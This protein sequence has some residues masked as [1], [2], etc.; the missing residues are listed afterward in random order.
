MS[1]QKTDNT[2]TAAGGADPIAVKNPLMEMV[3]V[4]A[5]MVVTMTSYT[6]MQFI[7]GMMVSRIG[8]DEVYV[9]AQGNGG[10]FVWLC[11]SFMLG[12]ATV[13][14]TYV[15]QHLGAGRPERGAAYAWNG[16]WLSLLGAIMMLPLIFALPWVFSRMNHGDQLHQL[17]T[18][19]A[20]I[21]LGGAFLTMG[22]RSIAHYFYG[23]H[24]PMVVMVS[25][26]LANIVNIGANALLIFG[27]AGPPESM[28]L[29]GPIGQLAAALNLPAMGVSGAAWGT[30][31]GT[32]VEFAIPMLVFVGPAMHRK[33]ATRTVWRPSIT[34]IKDIMRIGWPGGLMFFN[35]MVCWGYL[36]AFLLGAA[37]EAAGQ[38][39]E[40]HNTAG[41][42][43]LR[44]M[45]VSFM[46]A[47]G[48][49]IAVTAIVGRC[50]GMGRPDLAAKRAW[51][52]LK[53]TVVYMG[54]CGLA[55]IIFREQLIGVFIPADMPAAKVD[56]LVR[57]GAT[58]MIAAAVFQLFDAV[59]IITSGA[60]RGAGDT[61]WPGV[62]TVIASWT[63]IVGGG[64]LLIWLAPGLGSLGPW[65][66]ASAY[67]IV[68]GVAMMARF[69]GG[70]WRT[71]D[72][73][74][75]RD[76]EGI[77]DGTISLPG[78]PLTVPADAV[79][80]TTPGSL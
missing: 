14:N 5:P 17:E 22:A 9:S 50:M 24:R 69:I 46:P 58:V 1:S 70:R 32:C 18:Q 52:G 2:K 64:H 15:A 68:L 11:M 3:Q 77:G 26:L 61:V 72:L 59:A 19:Y 42:I 29:A 13:V 51:L 49:G 4:A 38:D 40:V 74:K 41:W 34:H 56:E 20:Q 30:V 57:V 36:M 37:G 43:A 65:I 12:L 23:M 76:E 79:A 25:V 48:L 10:M 27:A 28:P 53:V 8:P 6:V 39:A 63:C 67:I 73:L 7:D 71:I 44:Y 66:G 31:I 62:V 75:H 78:E 54:L 35:E 21:L 16:L 60:L 33:Y 47:V 55:F 80:G 45:H